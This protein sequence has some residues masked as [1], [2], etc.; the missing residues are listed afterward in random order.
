[1]SRYNPDV[2]DTSS[3]SV[4]SAVKRCCRCG[5][6]LTGHKRFKDRT[7]YWCRRC[8]DADKKLSSTRLRFNRKGK[9][10]KGMVAAVVGIAIVLIVLLWR[11]F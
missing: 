5:K 2:V 11:I 7:G 4:A 9:S 8:H 1:V 6:D 10:R 3:T